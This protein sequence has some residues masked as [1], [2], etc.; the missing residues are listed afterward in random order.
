MQR[1]SDPA[2]VKSGTIE[3]RRDSC[4]RRVAPGLASVDKLK[5]RLD[6]ASADPVCGTSMRR[7]HAWTV[8]Q[9]E[10]RRVLK[11]DGIAI[12]VVSSTTWTLSTSLS[13]AIG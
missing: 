9:A 2:L 11:P 6:G 13:H 4:F 10:L 7:S 5:D 1:E 8:L 12:H 3:A